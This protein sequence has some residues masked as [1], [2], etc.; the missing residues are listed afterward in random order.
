MGT[1]ALVPLLSTVAHPPRVARPPPPPPRAPRLAFDSPL[2]RDAGLTEE[3]EEYMAAHGHQRVDVRGC[4]FRARVE[5]REE[6]APAPSEGGRERKKR[7]IREEDLEVAAHRLQD[8]T[9]A[10]GSRAS[11]PPLDTN[12]FNILSPCTFNQLTD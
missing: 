7:R 1:R 5:Q 9:N 3:E 6:E 2:Q 4:R 10:F 11:L 8:V 12:I